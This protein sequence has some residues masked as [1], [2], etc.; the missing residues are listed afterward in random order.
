MNLGLF[1]TSL[2]AGSIETFNFSVGSEQE[3]RWME[4]NSEWERVRCY[5]KYKRLKR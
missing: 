3:V 4:K 2:V 1:K 5:R